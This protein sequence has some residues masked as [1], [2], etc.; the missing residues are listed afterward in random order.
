M[1]ILGRSSDNVIDVTHMST[2]N[3]VNT[4]VFRFA[5]HLDCGGKIELLESDPVESVPI[6]VAFVFLDV[7]LTPPLISC[8]PPIFKIILVKWILGTNGHRYFRNEM[9]WIDD[10][11]GSCD[12]AWWVSRWWDLEGMTWT[13]GVLQRD[14]AWMAATLKL[15]RSFWNEIPFEVNEA[16]VWILC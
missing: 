3:E 1:P 6:I 16:M 7:P 2:F 4:K 5:I 8:P 13:V 15:A 14:F 10:C 12:G 11:W 9:L